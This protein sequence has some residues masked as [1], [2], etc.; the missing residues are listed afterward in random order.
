MP[1]RNQT[2]TFQRK[3]GGELVDGF[4]TGETETPIVVRCSLQP[5][6]SSQMLALPEG[7]RDRSTYWLSC[8]IALQSVVQGISN[9]DLTNIGSDSYEVYSCEKWPTGQI[10]HFEVLIQ[11]VQ[12]A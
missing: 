11:K 8:D 3:S 7:R 9:P 1:I 5:A 4:W 2:L 12:G 10:P 6:T